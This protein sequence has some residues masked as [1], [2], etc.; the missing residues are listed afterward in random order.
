[1]DSSLIPPGFEAFAS[2]YLAKMEGD[3]ASNCASSAN[4]SMAENIQ[5]GTQCNNTNTSMSIRHISLI[6]Q[7]QL[8]SSSS[9][10]IELEQENFSRNWLPKGVLRGCEACENCQKVIAKWRPEE[11][12]RPD[13]E[14]APVFYPSEEE[15][16]DTIKYI[17]SIRSKAEM[18]GI[19]RIVPPPSW[20]PPCPLKEK[21]IW[22]RSKFTTRIQ[23]LDKL[24]NRE[25]MMQKFLVK[26][27]KRKKRKCLR[28]GAD[29]ANGIQDTKTSDN[30]E[31]FG[32][33]PGPDFT[34]DEFQ[35]YDDDFMA[36]YFWKNNN[37]SSL[38][39][40]SSTLDEQWHPTIQEIEGEY[41]RI[42]E[43]PTE[44]IEVLYGAD[45]ETGAFGSGFPKHSHQV[46]SAS[47]TKYINSGWNLN[48]FP[49]LPGS[50]LAFE[51][52]EISGVVVPWLYI[53]MCFSS[54]CWHVEDHHMYSLNYMHLGA[55]KMWYGVPGSDA[56]KLEAAMRKHLPDLFAEQPDLLHKLVTQ[57]SPSILSSE[58]V[59]V[60]RCVQN[61][62]EYIL[63]FP[64][65]YHAG[66]NCGFNCAEA[67]NIA[68]VDWLPHGHKAIELYREQGRRSSISHDKLLLGAAREAVKENWQHNFL[69]KHKSNNLRW[70]E[71]C[72][73]DGFLSKA[74]KTRVDMEH[75]WRELL[76]K[77]SKAL[78]MESSFD[79]NCERECSVCLFDLHLSAAGCHQCS[80]DKYACLT[81]AKQLCSCS[82]SAKFFL[83]RYDIMELNLL[84]E[85]LEGKLSAVY[86]WARL[87]MGLALTSHI[88]ESKQVASQE[89]AQEVISSAPSAISSEEQKRKA[90]E[91]SSSSA[92]Y[93][94]S[95]GSSKNVEPPSSAPSA[96]SSEE[97]KKK[98]LR[99]SSSSAKY[100]GSIGSS[101]N[102]E[103]PS[104][105]P[106]A[107]SSEEQKRKVPRGSSSSKKY[108]GSI[109]S[110]MNE[111][112]PFVVLAL[113]CVQ[114]ATRFKIKS[115][116]SKSSCKKENSLQSPPGFEVQSCQAIRPNNPAKVSPGASDKS[117]EKQPSLMGHKDV[118][119]LSDDEEDGP[120][121]KKTCVV[122][123][124]VQKDTIGTQ[125]PVFSDS[126]TKLDSCI[127][128]PAS[129][130]TV[131]LPSDVCIPSSTRVKVEELTESESS[132]GSNP[133]TSSCVNISQMD[134]DSNKIVGRNKETNDFDEA[135]HNPQQIDDEKVKELRSVDNILTVSN[136]SSHQH[137]MDGL[138][139]QKR[140]R[141]AKVIRR[142]SCNVEPLDFG[143]A[144]GA[145]LWCDSNSIYPKGF[146][147]RVRYIDVT[148]PTNMCYYISEI[149]DA[150]KDRPLF[151]VSLETD[152]SEVFV[153][154]SAGKCWE[155]VRERVNHEIAKQHKLGKGK[156]PTLQPPGSVDGMQMFGFSSPEIMQAI[157]AK[158]RD[159]VCQEYWQ[160]QSQSLMQIPSQHR[161]Q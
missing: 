136:P 141:I 39:D 16:E 152:P 73:K 150:G 41:W 151:M 129:A 14:D 57:L 114:R 44:E 95:I 146:R 96:I 22:E 120:P 105:A 94:G 54:F 126:M 130:A 76:S 40:S 157:Q 1:M 33:E 83:F 80:P 18:Y 32:F 31:Q 87:D 71:A 98:A 72:G 143:A 34:L 2:L 6:K 104:S 64:R 70:N 124:T 125:K 154:V 132:V 67:V 3:Q 155:L 36:Q 156:L 102:L 117:E 25:S 81:H 85:A 113:P 53:G 59:P 51:N 27:D 4:P 62:G 131:T 145:K 149:L 133:P 45:L 140:P 119:L 97:Q 111:E 30:A 12:R 19:C 107:I 138:P 15:F 137:S 106:S 21:N 49:R 122:R 47:D 11:A 144:H 9:D 90:P 153:H 78:K 99:G 68:P 79:A 93:V 109:G 63:T 134:T 61:P 127:D 84:V 8:D 74:L 24:Q 65:A 88:A 66:F 43:R 48:N 103:P 56:T 35:K 82:W 159:R 139:R 142:V 147:S 92:K 17:A 13:I 128:K 37:S 110:S 101:K 118:I 20:N 26:H 135:N 121:C 115:T 23:Q 55:P 112:L 7:N 161:D 86:R 58:G 10:Q 123:G 69:K 77:S 38:G 100:V 42:L 28:R 75:K 148:D 50:V 29:H 5:L 116:T 52:N 89:S 91:G 158:D 108:M 160:S 46:A 60:Y